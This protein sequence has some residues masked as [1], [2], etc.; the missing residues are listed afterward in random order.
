MHVNIRRPP[1]MLHSLNYLNGGSRAL[2]ERPVPAR[3]ATYL[4]VQGDHHHAGHHSKEL[5]PKS[6]PGFLF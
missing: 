1:N 4:G 2:S 3:L 5:G 6:T